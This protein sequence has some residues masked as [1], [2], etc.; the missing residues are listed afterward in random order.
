[1]APK[2]AGRS[3][4]CSNIPTLATIRFKA[5]FNARPIHIRSLDTYW[6]TSASNP[7]PGLLGMTTMRQTRFSSLNF[8]PHHKTTRREYFLGE[9]EVTRR[10]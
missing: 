6:G 1:M 8:D 2:G 9:M 5:E 4:S 3:G 7:P 10:G